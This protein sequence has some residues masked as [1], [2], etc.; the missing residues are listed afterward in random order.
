[1]S[2]ASRPKARIPATSARSGKIMR[3]LLDRVVKAEDRA[4]VRIEGQENLRVRPI[5]VENRK[6]VGDAPAG[7]QVEF[8]Q[9]ADG[10]GGESEGFHRGEAIAQRPTGCDRRR[11]FRSSI[12]PDKSPWRRPRQGRRPLALCG[13]PWRDPG[14]RRFR[15]DLCPLYSRPSRPGRMRPPAAGDSVNQT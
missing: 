2:P 1:M 13:R 14:G 4:E 15:R 5:R 6:N 10:E 9:A 3:G 11:G 8:I 12:P 7:V